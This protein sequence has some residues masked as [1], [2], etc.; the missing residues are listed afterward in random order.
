MFRES[1]SEQRAGALDALAKKI[2]QVKDAL[3]Q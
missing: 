2:R 3:V 1:P